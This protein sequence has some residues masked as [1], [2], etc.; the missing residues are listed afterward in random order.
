LSTFFAPTILRLILRPHPNSRGKYAD[1]F[2]A[3][4]DGK[5]I[6]TSREPLFDGARELLGRG[7]GPTTLVTT[8]HDGK[9]H[10]SFKPETLEKLAKLRVEESDG[11]GLKIR[12]WEPRQNT[13]SSVRGVSQTRVAAELG[14]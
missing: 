7:Y 10:D 5:F 13:V 14:E 4:L 2:D 12:R 1:T 11:G 9:P 3:Y 6:C 8:R